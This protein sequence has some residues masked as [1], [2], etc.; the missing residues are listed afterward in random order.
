MAVDDDFEAYIR[1]VNDKTR[2]YLEYLH[3]ENHMLVKSAKKLEM[4][5]QAL[6]A[7]VSAL[8]LELE[9]RTS[10]E[11]EMQEELRKIERE[12][13]EFSG[14]YVEVQRQNGNLA[15]MYVASYR[16][17]A[18]SKQ[19]EVLAAIKEIVANLVGSEEIAIFKVGA[20][21]ASLNLISSTGIDEAKYQ[22]VALESTCIGRLAQGKRVHVVEQKHPEEPDLKVCIPLRID[23]ALMG[24]IAIFR[25]L[26][27]KTAIARVDREVFDL[28][29]SQSAIALH[30]SS[31]AAD[32]DA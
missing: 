30:Y 12:S 18:T 10:R 32:A 14:R 27:Q 8:N 28:L 19:D 15:T 7:H 4:E 24:A 29:A 25:L 31:L 3:R 11:S 17:H 26:P 6:V 16:L 22:S 1:D 2:Q 5:H 13:E 20:E 21:S 23:G 9:R